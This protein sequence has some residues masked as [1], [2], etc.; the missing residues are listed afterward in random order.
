M[1]TVVAFVDLGDEKQNPDTHQ[2]RL[3]NGKLRYVHVIKVC[4]LQ[5]NWGLPLPKAKPQ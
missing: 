1:G 5:P 4:T 2:F 3:E